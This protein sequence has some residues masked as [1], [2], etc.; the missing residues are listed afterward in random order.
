M[1]DSDSSER[2][3]GPRELRPRG[4]GVAGGLVVVLTVAHLIVLGGEFPVLAGLPDWFY[5]FRGKELGPAA[6]TVGLLCLPWLGLALVR[7]DPPRPWLF[8]LALVVGGWMLQQGF[9]LL[10]GRGLDGVRDRMVTTGHSEFVRAAVLHDSILEVLTSYEGMIE[11][12][13]LGQYAPS[14]PP[15]QLVLYMLTDRLANGPN[16]QLV[17][18]TR[19]ERTQTCASLLWPLVCY[20]VLLPLYF[21]AR[22]LV[23]PVGAGVACVLYLVVPSVA[24][25]TLHAD[26]AFF[27]LLLLLPSWLALHGFTQRRASALLGAGVMTYVAGFCSFPLF[28]AL[29]LAAGV[30]FEAARHEGD[31]R[32]RRSRLVRA[33]VLLVAGV[34]LADGLCRV[35]LDYD[36]LLRY[37]G[38][39]AWH[40]AWQG[41]TPSMMFRLYYPSLNLLEYTAWVGVPIVV[42]ALASV[43]LGDRGGHGRPGRLRVLKALFFAVILF[44]ALFGRTKGEVA[45]LWLPLVP[46]LCLFAAS[47]PR[48]REGRGWFVGLVVTLQFATVY[49]TKA[50]Q[51]F[52]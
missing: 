31:S 7:R 27:P 34:V 51:D 6:L 41:W 46:F 3:D 13:E 5:E 23:G 2:G 17:E 24:L 14:K 36:L 49:L 15:G 4:L 33:G 19:M 48:V 39:I 9:G 16:S 35:A 32:A 18:H 1:T 8:L 29:P 20:L 38:A 43:G 10:E 45:R 52:F 40:T 11:A 47:H 37:R 44:L 50:H 25:M 42:L 21:V 22:A 30:V 12:A 26:Q 28:L